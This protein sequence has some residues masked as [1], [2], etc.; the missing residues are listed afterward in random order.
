MQ[1]EVQVGPGEVSEKGR[2]YDD[3]AKK[4]WLVIVEVSVRKI[5]VW[6][7]SGVSL[8]GDENVFKEGGNFP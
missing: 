2:N 7:K 5:G 6:M 3:G 8:Y 1:H 4:I